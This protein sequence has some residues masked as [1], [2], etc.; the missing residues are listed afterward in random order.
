MGSSRLPG[1][2]LMEACGRPLLSLMLDRV[3]RCETIDEIRVATSDREKDDEV[4]EVAR[5][6]GVLCFR[7]SESDVLDRYRGAA[8]RSQAD[9]VVRLTGDCPFIDPKVVD[10]VIRHY[11]DRADSVD[12]VSNILRRTYPQGLDT[13][14]FSRAALERAAAEARHPYHREHVTPYIHGRNCE[15]LPTGEFQ[16]SSVEYETDFS[17]L[18]LCV[19]ETEDYEFVRRVFEALLPENPGFSWLDVVALLTCHPDLLAINAQVEN[20]VRTT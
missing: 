20:T 14:V 8:E 19:D 2:V 1:K 12:Y 11:E 9:V 5:T 6:F 13:E 15:G 17:H 10:R 3:K 4:E 18:R 16:L 7:G